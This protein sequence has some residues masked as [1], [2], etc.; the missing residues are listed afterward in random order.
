MTIK[1]VM[2][3]TGC[4]IHFPDSNRSNTNEKSNQ[5]SIAGELEGVEKARACVR[6]GPYLNELSAQSTSDQKTLLAAF[7]KQLSILKPLVCVCERDR[8]RIELIRHSGFK[9][10]LYS[11]NLSTLV[12]KNIFQH[13]Y[14]ETT[15]VPAVP[16]YTSSCSVHLTSQPLSGCIWTTDKSTTARTCLD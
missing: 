11:L 15:F 1:K 5:V 2:E 10:D 4:H 6:V 12:K 3:E 14:I 8:E 13:A 16:D 9:F 7:I